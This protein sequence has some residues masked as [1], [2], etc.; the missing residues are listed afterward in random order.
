MKDNNRYQ[1]LA[2]KIKND[3]YITNKKVSTL[4]VVT[5]KW[6]DGR[7]DASAFYDRDSADRYYKFLSTFM[8]ETWEEYKDSLASNP[9]IDLQFVEADLLATEFQLLNKESN[10]ETI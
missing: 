10:N 8:I 9:V 1:H 2:D 7:V 4:Y 3:R 6:E 5:A